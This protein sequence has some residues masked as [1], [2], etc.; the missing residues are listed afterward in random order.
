MGKAGRGGL[1]S[2]RRG[3]VPPERMPGVQ[4]PAALAVVMILPSEEGLEEVGTILFC[5]IVPKGQREDLTKLAQVH[6]AMKLQRPRLS[7]GLVPLTP[8]PSICIAPHLST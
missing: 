3:T 8:K 1:R 6:K 4:H 7:P 2:Q 5:I